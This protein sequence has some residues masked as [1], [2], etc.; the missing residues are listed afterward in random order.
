M[1]TPE[2]Q[3]EVENTSLWLETYTPASTSENCFRNTRVGPP[4][5]LLKVKAKTS[6]TGE[7]AQLVPE[8]PPPAVCNDPVSA[9]TAF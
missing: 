2:V 7:S 4:A 9:I 1:K 8:K 3:H 6:R 5:H